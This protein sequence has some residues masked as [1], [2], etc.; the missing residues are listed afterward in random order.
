MRLVEVKNLKGNE[1]IGEDIIRDNGVVLLNRGTRYRTVFTEKLLQYRIERI[2]IEDK[3][4]EGIIPKPIIE[5]EQ[6][7]QLIN[8]FRGEFDKIL[9]S[10]VVKLEPIKKIA[11]G[12]AGALVDKDA[13]YDLINVRTNAYNIYEH[14]IEVTILVYMMCK[15]LLIPVN[16][17]K[18]IVIGSLLHDIGMILVPK[19]ILEKP[20]RLSIQE[21]KIIERHTEWGYQMIKDNQS[22]GPLAKLVVLC[23][24]ERE[25]GSGYPLGKGED[26]HIGAKIV[27]AC[28]VFIAITSE[29]CY[30]QGVGINEAV[31]M[32]RK[33]NLNEKVEKTL[34]SMLNFYPVGSTVLLSNNAVALV[35]KNYS[36]NLD[37][38]VVRVIEENGTELANYYRLDLMQEQSIHIVE[39][40][41]GR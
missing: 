39:I 14:S 27:A 32:L 19:E 16:Q 41:N 4:S 30:R 23:H 35:E 11:D 34:E 24:H 40:V 20:T 10:K 31:I 33:E 37:R 21:G 29:R 3:L 13:V 22:I 6:K 8:D 1:I 2:Y 38:P 26:L 15:K 12:I 9:T 36:E 5:P 7:E 18:E 28:D 17:T 25:D